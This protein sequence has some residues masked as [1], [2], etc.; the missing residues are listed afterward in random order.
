MYGDPELP[1]ALGK[2]VP[3]NQLFWMSPPCSHPGRLCFTG[4]EIDAREGASQIP[5]ESRAQLSPTPA[6]AAS[7]RRF[8]K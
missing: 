7:L 4:S 5:S 6:P 2:P 8:P 1:R 3:C